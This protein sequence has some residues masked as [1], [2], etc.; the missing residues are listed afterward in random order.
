MT[1]K[2]IVG[3]MIVLC[4]SVMGNLYSVKFKRKYDFFVC[5]EDFALYLKREI[6]F[7]SSAVQAIAS[8]FKTD[9]DDLREL[10]SSF[11]QSGACNLPKYITADDENLL[12][13]FFEKIGRSDRVNE[14][15]M[16]N[17]FFDDVRAV[18]ERERIRCQRVGGASTKIGFFIGLILFFVLV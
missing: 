6:A 18:K 16:I 11:S 4:S 9:N 7:S 14:I 5:L 10:L 13:P 2:I 15:E 3:L 12:I 8:S 1:V 17:T